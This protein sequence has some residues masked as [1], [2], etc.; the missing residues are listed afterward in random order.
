MQLEFV[1]G[2][3]PLKLGQAIFGSEGG[4]EISDDLVIF[5]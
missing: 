1:P 4:T 2:V 5:V 3:L